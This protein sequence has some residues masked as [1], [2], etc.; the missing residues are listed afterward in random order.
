MASIGDIIRLTVSGKYQGQDVVNVFFYE[1]GA[2]TTGAI[3]P[4]AWLPDWA[5]EFEAKVLPTL[6]T[7][8]IYDRIVYD[9]LTDG[10]EFADVGI[11]ARGVDGSDPLPSANAMAVKMSRTTKITRNG[12]KRYAGLTETNVSGN[13]LT[14]GE[15]S[16][17]DIEAFHDTILQIDDY[18]MSGG[19]LILV[20]VIV[21]RTK[22]GSGV[23]QLD[24]SKINW[25]S[26]A[27]VKSL[28][29]TQNSRK[30]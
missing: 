20:N 4:E 23:Y 28:T 21:G 6:S 22:D 19:T 11:D 30:P 17:A 9:N 26:D 13:D 8:L 29:S 27:Q 3:V 7:D 12:A 1:I 18:D 5:N 25:V 10:L 24:L 15:L 16:K 2:G 14:I